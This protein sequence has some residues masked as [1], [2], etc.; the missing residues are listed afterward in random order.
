MTQHTTIMT[1]SSYY[2]YCSAWCV[3]NQTATAE[4]VQIFTSMADS[5]VR[6]GIVFG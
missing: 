4:Q 1:L 2:A 3:A 5:A 6:A